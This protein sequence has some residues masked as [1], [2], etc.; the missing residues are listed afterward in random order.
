M[1]LR[2]SK[3]FF[4][5]VLSLVSLSLL[6]SP[7]AW[8]DSLI[9]G[10]PSTGGNAF[11]FGGGVNA[12]ATRYQQAYAAIDF[13]IIGSPIS[14]TSIDFLGGA[15]TLAPSTYTL[16]FS[17]ITAGIDSLSNVAFDSNRGPDNAFF[18]SLTLSGP[19][20]ATLTFT[21]VPFNYNPANGNLLLDIVV[22]PG[23]VDANNG[24]GAHYLANSSAL[25]VFSRYHNFGSGTVGW[26]LVTQ[27]DFTIPEPATPSL[28]LAAFLVATFLRQGRP[29]KS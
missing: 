25:G 19:A 9:V 4:K 5:R 8:S 15:G 29:R 22:S 1:T 16:Y 14:I 24:Y 26:G 23:G 11:P 3:Q 27:F 13:S 20:P 10:Q 7:N 28:L 2:A 12:S 18:A 6:F 17:T 21:G